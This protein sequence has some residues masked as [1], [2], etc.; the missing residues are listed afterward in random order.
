MYFIIRINTFLIIG[1][2]FQI[3]SR[4]I[5]L[6]HFN[7]LCMSITLSTIKLYFND[8]GIIEV[9]IFATEDVAERIADKEGV[10]NHQIGTVM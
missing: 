7:R 3:A 5:M 6:F 10:A 8:C 2:A 4:N 9:G 1:K